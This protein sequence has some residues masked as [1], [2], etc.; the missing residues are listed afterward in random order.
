[1]IRLVISHQ[2]TR[3]D[4]FQST[5]NKPP[6]RRDTDLTTFGM[7][8]HLVSRVQQPPQVSELEL[9]RLSTDTRSLTE[10]RGSGPDMIS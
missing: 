4:T 2:K 3:E 5:P 10:S 7:G 8:A 9:N 1:M 6:Y